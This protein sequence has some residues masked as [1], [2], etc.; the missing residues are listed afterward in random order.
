MLVVDCGYATAK[1]DHTHWNKSCGATGF[2][3][4]PTPNNPT[5][6]Q[7][8][9]TVALT[10]PPVPIAQWCAGVDAPM[11]SAAALRDEL[12]RLLTPPSIGVS[13]D[14]GTGL[15]NLKTLYWVHTASTVNLGRAALVGFPVELRVHYLRTDFDFGDGTGDT[16]AP[17]P[18]TPYDPSHDCGN[19]AAEFGHTYRGAGPVTVTARTYWQG[20]YRIAGQ[21][22]QDIP[23]AVTARQ[24]AT[25]A[26]TVRQAHSTLVSR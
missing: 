22:W 20:Q 25:A 1:D 15:V 8:M 24:P 21:Q 3:C 14:T 17:T 18:G 11:P 13:P 23:G 9:T 19:C 10:D 2:P 26:L 12:I 4:P 6:H 5:P 16:L 7:F